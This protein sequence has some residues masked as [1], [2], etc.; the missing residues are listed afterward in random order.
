MWDDAVLV[1]ASDNGGC[2]A[3]GGTNYPLRGGKHFL[4]DGGVKVPSFIYSDLIPEARRDHAY[5]GL[6]HV[7]D[8]YPTLVRLVS[9]GG[10]VD[11]DVAVV[12]ALEKL[13]DVDG[14]YQ[15]DALM[16]VAAPPRVEVPINVQSYAFTC[17]GANASL[18][19]DADSLGSVSQCADPW[20][21]MVRQGNAT[22]AALRYGDWKLLVN[23]FAEPWYGVPAEG[24]DALGYDLAAG[25]PDLGDDEGPMDN[26]GTAVGT[27]AH[28]YLFNLKDDPSE[29]VDL[30][31]DFPEVRDVIKARLTELMKQEVAS[32]WKAETSLAYGAWKDHHMCISPWIA[33]GDSADFGDSR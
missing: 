1:F 17:T 7:T 31:D 21:I 11:D 13:D 9:A 32:I 27:E 25:S 4:W 6:F 23:E 15:W 18:L 16:G 2:W 24:A 29:S 12:D 3:Q 30:S 14:L 8:W 28:T 5:T 26:C 10:Q 19:R 33:A 22:R 20:H